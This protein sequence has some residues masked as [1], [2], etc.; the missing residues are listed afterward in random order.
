MWAGWVHHSWRYGNEEAIC[1]VGSEM[2]ERGTERSKVSVVWIIFGFFSSRSKW[3]PVVNGDR[4]RNLIISVWP[5]DKATIE[6]GHS[7]S[8]RPKKFRVQKSAGKILA[9]NFWDQDGILLVDYLPKDQTIIADYY[10]SLLVQLK[11][12]LKEKRRGKDTKVHW[13]LAIQKKLAYLGFQCIDHPPYSPDLATSDYHLFPGL[14]KN[15]WKVA[16][17]RPTQRPLL[18]R[19][20]G[21]KDN[22]LIFFFSVACK[23]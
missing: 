16:I 5:G 2:P 1:E 7:G 12:I 14:K 21:W 9:S 10:S 17:F 19:R 11:D 4:G 6:W 8:P 15:N 13:A 18:S 20:P 23:S 3:C 22:L